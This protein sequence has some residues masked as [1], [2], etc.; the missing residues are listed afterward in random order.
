MNMV[1]E[2]R[3]I[4]VVDDSDVIRDFLQLL[5][6]NAGYD[7]RVAAD[8]REGLD[9][10]RQFHPDLIS[11]DISMPVMDGFQFLLHLRSDFR[12]PLP[13]VIV[14]SGFDVTAE[15][16]LAL[17]AVR[18][19]AKPFES[20]VFLRTVEQVLNGRPTEPSELERERS[21]VES[22]RAR[23]AAAAARLSATLAAEGPALERTLPV[24]AEWVSHYFGVAPAGV[25][26]VENDGVRVAGVS[27]GSVVPAGTKLSSKLL[28]ATGVLAAGSS[29][30]ATENAE[31]LRGVYGDAYGLQFLVAVPLLFEDVP[32][33]ALGLFDK[34]PHLFR[35]E[36]LL[37]L[38][39]VGRNFSQA[40]HPES[41]LVGNL[42]F[43]PSALFDL[44]L[45]SELA[46]LHRERGAL[47]LLV[48]ELDTEAIDSEQALEILHRGSPRLA[49]C[50]R[51]RGAMALFKRDPNATTARDVIEASLSALQ[52]IAVVR[53]AGWISIIDNGL[54]PVPGEIALR[55]AAVALDHSRSTGGTRIERTLIVTE[56]TRDAAPAMGLHT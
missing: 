45:A 32:I 13:P 4:L 49:L 5:L 12:P 18:F 38:E 56:P 16:A 1:T 6:E 55:L 22:A 53:A 7:V 2:R 31:L 14:S 42:G 46:L 47:E 34:T 28:F 39:G 8:G 30:L 19:V 33:G 27:H 48:V 52:A 50:R 54:A 17:G 44:M 10:V 51:D 29:F 20:A 26:L 21:A 15:E 24:V 36:D 3:R 35:A 43:I 9:A 25:A 40:L 11:T 23:A 41:P 37:I